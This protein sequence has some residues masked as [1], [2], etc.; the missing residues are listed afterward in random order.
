M[1]VLGTARDVHRAPLA[2]EGAAQVE[3]VL[4]DRVDRGRAGGGLGHGGAHVLG[5]ASGE[6]FCVFGPSAM[7]PVNARARLI[8][9]APTLGGPET[10]ALVPAVSSHIRLTPAERQSIGIADGLVRLS[11]GLEHIDDLKADLDAGLRGGA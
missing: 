4:L 9:L 8:R 11:C 3:A 7:S 10:I 2:G 5:C 1:A 6:G